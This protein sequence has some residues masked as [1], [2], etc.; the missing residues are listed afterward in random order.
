MPDEIDYL[1]KIKR[2]R[3]ID[4][5]L[6]NEVFRDMECVEVLLRVILG[7]DDIHVFMSM[8]QRTLK[9]FGRSLKLDVWAEDEDNPYAHYNIEVQRKSRGA[10]VRRARFH[11]GALDFF[12]LAS[13]DDFSLLADNYVIFITEHDVLKRGLPLYTFGRYI[14]ETHEAVN[15]GSHIIY[16]NGECRDSSTDLGRLMQDFF[17]PNPDKMNYP[18]LAR[19]V[20]YLKEGA[21]TRRMSI[22][23]QEL[24]AEELAAG[25]EEAREEALIAGRKAGL[26]AGREAGI[27]AGREAG[28]TAGREQ[29][30]GSFITNMLKA[31]K[32]AFTEIAQYAGVP[33]ARVRTIADTLGIREA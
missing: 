23:I 26:K 17:E 31:G 1:G 30:E 25:R 16:V 9:T 15:D 6:M 12:S 5:V 2:L 27:K 18:V 28:I 4:D 3:L 7:R 22:T 21:G 33:I 29:A 8:T 20:K 10:D 24:F 19:R 32:L 11:S 13:G 14:N